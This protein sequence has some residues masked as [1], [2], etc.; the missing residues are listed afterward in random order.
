MAAYTIFTEGS[1]FL[2]V[3]TF[4]SFDIL[5]MKP[6]IRTVSDNSEKRTHMTLSQISSRSFICLRIFAK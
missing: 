1:F 3:L 6:A 4:P 2:G 5:L